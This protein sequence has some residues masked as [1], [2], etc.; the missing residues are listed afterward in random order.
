MMADDQALQGPPIHLAPGSP[1]GPK[2]LHLINPPASQAASRQRREGSHKDYKDISA[3][4]FAGVGVASFW[5]PH[6]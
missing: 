2:P 5:P 4:P 6:L 3:A 1:G